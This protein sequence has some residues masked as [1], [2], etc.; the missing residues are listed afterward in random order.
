LAVLVTLEHLPQGVGYRAH[1]ARLFGKHVAR[2][3]GNRVDHEDPRLRVDGLGGHTLDAGTQ[4]AQPLVDALIAA[5]DLADV[6]NLAA[7]LRAQG[8]EQHRHAGADVGRLH[9]LA[10]QPP[11]AG[12][13]RA[14]RIAKHDV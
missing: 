9:A 6:A 12:D 13:D 11:R 10:T 7:S 14:V 1:L 2:A 3:A 8:C 5:I 4:L